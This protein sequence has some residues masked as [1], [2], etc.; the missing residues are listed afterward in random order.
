MQFG[1]YLAACGVECGRVVNTSHRNN[2]RQANFS[3]IQQAVVI[4]RSQINKGASAQN[5]GTI[6]DYAEEFI[7]PEDQT[8]N[9]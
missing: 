2:G 7:R 6:P 9:F 1:R 3:R 4:A 8:R 5:S